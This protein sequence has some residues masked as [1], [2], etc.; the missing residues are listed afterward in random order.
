MDRNEKFALVD[1]LEREIAGVAKERN[2]SGVDL[3]PS[4]DDLTRDL[5]ASREATTLAHLNARLLSIDDRLAHIQENTTPRVVPDYFL[6]E[7][8]RNTKATADIARTNQR[9]VLLVALLAIFWSAFYWW[10]N[11]D[12]IRAFIQAGTSF[13]RAFIQATTN[14][15]SHLFS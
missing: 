3:L 1:K 7:I 12:D 15:I 14:F 11:Y 5:N 9:N 4:L 10:K 8:K 6:N 13:T 2:S